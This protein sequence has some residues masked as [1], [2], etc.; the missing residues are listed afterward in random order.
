MIYDKKINCIYEVEIGKVYLLFGILERN[1]LLNLE[2][3][4]F[5]LIDLL[6]YI[7]ILIDCWCR[8]WLY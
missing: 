4:S 5:W 8:C 1:K 6:K 7:M 3:Y 2:E